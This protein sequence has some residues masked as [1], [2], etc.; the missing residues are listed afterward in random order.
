MR[1]E[2][3]CLPE[4]FVHVAS[5]DKTFEIRKNDRNFEVGDRLRIR[6]WEPNVP[7]YTGRECIR[8]V[9]YMTDYEQKPG[10]VVLALGVSDE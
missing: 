7:D 5:G 3:K 9:T 10:Y 2:L 1:H 4:Y 8:V 6:E